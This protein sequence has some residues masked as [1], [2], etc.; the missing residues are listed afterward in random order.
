MSGPN[1]GQ[2]AISGETL[3]AYRQVYAAVVA[4]AVRCLAQAN[5]EA[6]PGE[7]PDQQSWGDL[8]NTS[9]S[10]FM[11]QARERLGIVDH[12]AFLVLVR[13]GVVD[14]DDL[15]DGGGAA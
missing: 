3:D 13:T 7:W 6:E 14:V 15:W 11:R 5:A 4:E 1:E 8:G 10:V 12:D 2:P 9:R